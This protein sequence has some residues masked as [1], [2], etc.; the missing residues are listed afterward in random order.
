[1]TISPIGSRAGRSNMEKFNRIKIRSTNDDI[2]VIDC[3]PP[4]IS[5]GH[6]EVKNNCLIVT[7][8]DEVEIHIPPGEYEEIEVETVNGDCLL[9]LTKTTVNCVVFA[10][11]NGDLIINGQCENVSFTSMNGEYI[12]TSFGDIIHQ[13]TRQTRRVANINNLSRTRNENERY[14]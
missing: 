3:M 6:Y 14:K 1:M 10:S 12:R 4:Y 11:K 8:D 9:N 13:P 2:T 5:G 7:S